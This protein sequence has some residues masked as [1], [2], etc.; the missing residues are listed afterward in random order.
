[1]FFKITKLL[2]FLTVKLKL[3][4]VTIRRIHRSSKWFTLFMSRYVIT[5]FRVFF[6]NPEQSLQ[7]FINCLV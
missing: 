3:T 2:L 7:F 5:P 4:S 1:M 6:I